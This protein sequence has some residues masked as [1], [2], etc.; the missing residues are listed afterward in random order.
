MATKNASHATSPA[1]IAIDHGRSS[2]SL[3]R[4]R[5]PAPRPRDSSVSGA[6]PPTFTKQ[7]ISTK[8][9]SER[10]RVDVED[11]RRSDDPDEDAGEHR[12]EYQRDA[13]CRLQ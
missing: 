8:A 10:G 2:R 9:T 4:N 5:T 7:A 1:T 13:H 6:A 3:S 11:V 12:T